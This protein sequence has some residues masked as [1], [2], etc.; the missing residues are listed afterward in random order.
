LLSGADVVAGAAEVVTAGADVEAGASST[1][2][3]GFR[4]R[5]DTEDVRGFEVLPIPT[6]KKLK[7]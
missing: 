7:N 1:N 6:F 5:I 2:R 3:G 4:D